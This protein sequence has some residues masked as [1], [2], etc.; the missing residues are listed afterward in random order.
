MLPWAMPAYVSILL[1][2][3]GMFNTEFG[4]LEPV[5]HGAGAAEVQ[6]SWHNTVTAFLACLALNLWMALPFMI[7]HH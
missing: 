2:R 5:A 3:V 6:T 7:C 4:L 1:W